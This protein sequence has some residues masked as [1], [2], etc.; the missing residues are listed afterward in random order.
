MQSPCVN[1]CVMDE[2]NRHCR[3]CFR[4]LQEIAA[5]SAMTDAERAGVMAEL[6]SRRPASNVVE[7]SRPPLP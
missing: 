7:V 5:W 2:S 3:G 1:V 6:P 4:T